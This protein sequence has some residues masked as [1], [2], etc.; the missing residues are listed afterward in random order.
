MS[1]KKRKLVFSNNKASSK[2]QGLNSRPAQPSSSRVRK[3]YRDDSVSSNDLDDENNG[4]AHGSRSSQIDISSSSD[5][6]TAGERRLRLAEQYLENI[7]EEIDDTGF[8]AE[9]IDRDL[10]AERLKE[11][12]A[13]TKGKLYRRIASSLA[14]DHTAYEHCRFNQHSVNGVATCGRYIYTVSKNSTLAKWALGEENEVNKSLI[15]EHRLRI[16]LSAKGDRAQKNNP[17]FRGHIGQILCVAASS[18]GTFVVTGGTDRRLIVWDA[19]KLSPVKVFYQHRDAVTGVAFRRN[20]N[21]LFSCSSDRTIKVWSLDELAYVETL[22]GHQD[23]VVDVAALTLERCV[24]VGARDR[25]AR[26]WKVVEESQLVFRGGGAPRSTERPSNER[27][28]VGESGLSEIIPQRFDEGSLDRVALI[29]EETFVTGGDNG[30]LSLWN[31]HKKKPVHVIPAAHG[32]DPPLHPSQAFAEENPTAKSPGP[33]LPRWI[34]ALCTLPFADVVISGS[35][36]DSVRAWR[37]SDDKKRLEP[38][39]P[40]LRSKKIGS[41]NAVDM[42]PKGLRSNIV[43]GVINDLSIYDAA[44]KGDERLYVFAGVGR[45]QRLGRW[46]KMSGKPGLALFTIP[47][48]LRSTEG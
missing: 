30:M 18:T 33:P 11:D 24:S 21:Q 34:T 8:D 1:Q 35:W 41:T 48:R 13:E 43:K 10:V 46:I 39:G 17:A 19:Y 7:R 12:V 29:D 26:L 36:N 42:R 40:L 15:S 5:G 45:E 3:S 9:E 38:L 37:I 16:L 2:R 44:E 32:Y 27:D 28:G 25:T 31:I 23:K 20:T 14:L 6:E 22:F 4:S 47:Y